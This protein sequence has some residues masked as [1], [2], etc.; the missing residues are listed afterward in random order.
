MGLEEIRAEID[1]IDDELL[2]LLEKRFILAKKTRKFKEKTIDLS[3]EKQI[4]SRLKSSSLTDEQIHKIFSQ[5]ITECRN[6]Q[7]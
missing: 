2:R 5:I 7:D 4:Y 6:A 3:R 1:S